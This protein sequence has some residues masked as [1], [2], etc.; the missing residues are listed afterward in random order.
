VRLVVIAVFPD[1]HAD[2]LGG[3][4]RDGQDLQGH[5]AQRQA[6]PV[7]QGVGGE[8]YVGGRAVGDDRAGLGGQLQVPAEEVGVDVGLYHPLDLQPPLGGFLEVD[9]DVAARINHDRPVVSS[10]I[11]YEACDRQAR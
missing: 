2:R 5:L 3:V 6:L 1:D 11:R 9:A 4:A 8:A 7:L 10:P